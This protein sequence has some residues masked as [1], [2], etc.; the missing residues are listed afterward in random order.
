V[1]LETDR[2]EE[3]CREQAFGLQKKQEGRREAGIK[4]LVVEKKKSSCSIGE[5]L[6]LSCKQQKL[7]NGKNVK[8]AGKEKT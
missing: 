6:G 3:R 1:T 5:V 2:G 4:W 8:K 7:G